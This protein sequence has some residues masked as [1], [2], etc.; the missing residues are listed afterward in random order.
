VW[1]DA[2]DTRT[3]D[4]IGK[5]PLYFTSPPLLRQIV[6]RQI[7]VRQILVR[8]ILVRQIVVRQIVVR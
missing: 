2:E 7:V 6:V 1:G 5:P 4:V 3:M 8:Q